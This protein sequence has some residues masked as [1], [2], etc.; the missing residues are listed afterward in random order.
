MLKGDTT[1]ST[2]NT[3]VIKDA[4]KDLDENSPTG[5]IKKIP[6]VDVNAVAMK[7]DMPAIDRKNIEGWFL[8]LDYWFAAM[9]IKSDTQKYNSAMAALGPRVLQD[10]LATVGEVPEQ[11]RYEFIKRRLITFCTDSQQRRLNQML[12]ET[13]LGDQR[14]SQLFAEMMRLVGDTMSESAVKNIWAKRL[15]IYAQAA[16]AACTGPSKEYLKIAD[17]IVDT[18]SLQVNSSTDDQSSHITPTPTAVVQRQSR[19]EYHDLRNAVYELTKRLDR[20]SVERGRQR[21]RSRPSYRRQS[22]K[23]QRSSTPANTDECWYHR[24]F[25]SSSKNCRPPCRHYKPSNNDN[26]AK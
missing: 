9:G 6:A 20:M 24:K 25:G 16:V 19:G 11:A 5:T 17:A 14:P 2:E 8:S 26:S 4:A 22:Q 23:R 18:I 3:A 15:P 21:E 10:F 13:Q 12:N 7:I 1:D